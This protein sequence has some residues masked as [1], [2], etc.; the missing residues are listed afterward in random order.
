MIVN[1]DVNLIIMICPKKI[2]KTTLKYK[3]R[4]I[5]RTITACADSNPGLLCP[6]QNIFHADYVY[7]KNV[8]TVL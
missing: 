6:K 1:S 3:A 8:Y 7:N 4:P 2:L 5:N